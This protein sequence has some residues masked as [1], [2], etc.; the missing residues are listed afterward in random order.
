[1]QNHL[2][3]QASC[4]VRR[5][6]SIGAGPAAVVGIGGGLTGSALRVRV[7]NECFLAIE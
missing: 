1:M 5:H 6:V 7:E 4:G 2:F 3:R